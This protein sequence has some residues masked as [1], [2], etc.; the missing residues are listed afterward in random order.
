MIDD[1]S[2]YR[3]SLHYNVQTDAGNVAVSHQLA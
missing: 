1:R 2:M 3:S